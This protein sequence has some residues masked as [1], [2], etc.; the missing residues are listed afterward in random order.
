MYI[1]A[2]YDIN[3]KRVNKVHNICAKYLNWIQNSI[4]EGE[5]TLSNLKKF[6]LELKDIIIK[7]EKDSLIIFKFKRKFDF[8][9]RIIGFEKAPITNILF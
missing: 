1:I 9:K 2:V 6:E 4:F 7:E 3:Q 8:E 5:I